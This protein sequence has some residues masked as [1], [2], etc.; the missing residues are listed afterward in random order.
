MS[1]LKLSPEKPNCR[2]C[3]PNYLANDTVPMCSP[4]L[5]SESPHRVF[6]VLFLF[7]RPKMSAA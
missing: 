1:R 2:Q 6:K 5:S 4:C 3:E 7:I